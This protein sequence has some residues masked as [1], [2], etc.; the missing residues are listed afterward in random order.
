MEALQ[1]KSL[2][3]VQYPLLLLFCAPWFLRLKDWGK[4]A[5][6]RPGEAGGAFS[7]SGTIPPGLAADQDS[8]T[9]RHASHRLMH[10][11]K[12]NEIF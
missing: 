9:P 7:S 5:S 6:G 1:V 4:A 2:G 3:G 11:F 8:V 12:D 10:I